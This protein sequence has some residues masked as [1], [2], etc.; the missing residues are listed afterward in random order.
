MAVDFDDPLRRRVS[1]QLQEADLTAQVLCKEEGEGM[2]RSSTARTLNF[3]RPL[4]SVPL[5]TLLRATQ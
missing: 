3:S 5:G 2:V 1:N 4:C